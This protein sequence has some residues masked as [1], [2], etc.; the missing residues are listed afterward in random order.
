MFTVAILLVSNIWRWDP[1]FPSTKSLVLHFLSLKLHPKA[2]KCSQ[3]VIMHSLMSSWPTT[4]P[5]SNQPIELILW[6]SLMIKDFYNVSF[7]GLG[8]FTS[9]HNFICDLSNLI[10][11]SADLVLVGWRNQAKKLI[12]K[13]TRK[14]MNRIRAVWSYVIGGMSDWTNETP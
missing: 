4:N 3:Q 10:A 9:H 1:N 6:S 5:S 13:K 12:R 7:F 8:F 2:S 14:N 11:F